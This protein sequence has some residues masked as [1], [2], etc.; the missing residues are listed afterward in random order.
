MNS[1]PPLPIESGEAREVPPAGVNKRQVR[2]AAVRMRAEHRR[3]ESGELAG[4]VVRPAAP[5]A[6]E[7]LAGAA[8]L[9]PVAGAGGVGDGVFVPAD[10][11]S[12]APMRQPGAVFAERGGAFGR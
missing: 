10:T 5:V 6:S 7:G 4:L 1:A 11:V 8:A 2:P 3:L 12:G 9:F